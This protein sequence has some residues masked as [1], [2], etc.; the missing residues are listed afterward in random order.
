MNEGNHNIEVIIPGNI[1]KAGDY[2]L[3]IAVGKKNH[4]SL[5][6][7][8]NV[9]IFSITDLSSNRSMKSIDNRRNLVSPIINWITKY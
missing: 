7:H 9:V 3:S 6:K 4:G 5:D 2:S 1:F 8:N